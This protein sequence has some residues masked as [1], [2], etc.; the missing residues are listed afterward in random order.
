[1]S[2]N[3]SQVPVRQIR[4]N[5]YQVALKEYE[6]DLMAEASEQ[7]KQFQRS[8]A[9]QGQGW[10]CLQ[11][12]VNNANDARR[13]SWE[14]TM[15][16]IQGAERQREWD[17]Q[18]EQ[19]QMW[20]K[21][22]ESAIS[23][24]G[25]ELSFYTEQD[26][27][28][29]A[30][31]AKTYELAALEAQKQENW[32]AAKEYQRRAEIAISQARGVAGIEQPTEQDYESGLVK[33]KEAPLQVEQGPSTAENVARGII[34]GVKEGAGQVY[35]HTAQ[36]WSVMVNAAQILAKR[37]D[38]SL[39]EQKFLD[40]VKEYG[41]AMSQETG[42]SYWT[43]RTTG[44]GEERPLSEVSPEMYEAY[45][46]LGFARQLI[47]EATWPGWLILGEA[48]TFTGLSKYLGALA[49]KAT[50]GVMRGVEKG[51]IG[52]AKGAVKPGV[53]VE[54]GLVKLLGLPFKATGKLFD[55]TIGK[56]L[57]KKAVENPEKANALLSSLDKV[58]RGE[59]LN[60]DDIG[61]LM[62]FD[63][64]L[65]EAAKSIAARQTAQ[66]VTPEGT[67]V[68]I[69][70]QAAE[71]VAEQAV[72][73][74]G[75]VIGGGTAYNPMEGIFGFKNIDEA[76]AQ[77]YPQTNEKAVMRAIGKIPGVGSRIVRIIDPSMTPRKSIEAQAV[78]EYAAVFNHRINREA[79]GWK[80]IIESVGN[81]KFPTSSAKAYLRIENGIVQNVD[82]VKPKTQGA[83]MAI[84][85][86]LEHPENYV[87]D[88]STQALANLWKQIRTNAIREYE[89]RGM[90]FPA[91]FRFPR[92]VQ[93]AHG[94]SIGFPTVRLKKPRHYETMM[95]GLKEGVEY[96]D[97]PIQVMQSFVDE[98]TRIVA[99]NDF[100]AV[101]KAMG[102]TASERVPISIK[103][104]RTAA[105]NAVKDINYSIAT[106]RRM[107]TTPRGKESSALLQSQQAKSLALLDKRAPQLATRIRAMVEMPA[108]QRT[109]EATQIVKEL[110]AMLPSVR[111]EAAK[112]RLAYTNALRRAKSPAL[113]AG[114]AGTKHPAFTGR[115][116]SEET[117]RTLNEM[118]P[119]KAGH[120]TV[121][122][123]QV[124][125][126][127]RTLVANLDFSAWF[128][129]GQNV[130]ARRPDKWTIGVKESLKA[131]FDP[132]TLTKYRNTA[133]NIG[134]LSRHPDIVQ[135][136]HEFFTGKTALERIPH[137]GKAIGKIVAPFERAFETFGDVAR[138]EMAKALEPA[139]VKAGAQNQLGTYVNRLT[140]VMNTK[141]LGISGTQR[142]VE[143][144]WVAFAPRFMRASLAYIGTIFEKGITGA[145][146]RRTLAQ[147]AAGG[148]AAY[149]G[150]TQAL[151]QEAYL[152][153]RD[154]KFFTIE[155]GNRRIGVGGFMLSFVR[156]MGDIEASLSSH[157]GNEPMDLLEFHPI[158]ARKTNPIIKY[159]SSKA[160]I[161]SSML[162][163]GAIGQDYIGYPLE[164]PE[165][166]ARWLIV[167]HSLP[168]ALQSQFRNEY[169]EPPENRLAVL[170]AEMLGMR[171]YPDEP[172]YE[173]ADQYAQQ[174][175]GKDWGD[176]YQATK[177]GS[178][179][180]SER[181]EKLI[182]HFP[183][184]K[185]AYEDYKPKATKRW[186][187]AH[188]LL[189]DEGAVKDYY[190]NKLYKKKWDDLTKQE[191][192]QTEAYRV[193]DEATSK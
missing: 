141:A 119:S 25:D 161:L 117:A 6:R 156:F 182:E 111:T 115:I 22:R 90:K 85:D 110:Q 35:R 94:E 98:V 167:E 140:A 54:A 14:Y 10:S 75:K 101:V 62:D 162:Y 55:K 147:M 124:A 172:F 193:Y 16:K 61:R 60:T 21:M 82:A 171:V 13:V 33:R 96:V 126:S 157:R 71:Q 84:G 17:A 169:E 131:F 185:E 158:D 192:Q 184:L 170:G 145:E 104:W 26:K 186:Q 50:G 189:P 187:T 39:E 20:G 180:K 67:V 149:Y 53:W 109:R 137:I 150:A 139:F 79:Q 152:D 70:Q 103:N 59:A 130:L 11:S 168:I 127:L 122:A 52:L 81:G 99:A 88:E 134:I 95:Q 69:A 45:E 121:K 146:A 128:Y 2:F 19:G 15:Q 165:D 100:Q 181:Q 40:L 118:L 83:S 113:G 129:Q 5:A 178:Y 112:A 73:T 34:G 12:A 87:L 183:D 78:Q 49:P 159:V 4:R 143:S 80:A 114:E 97:D 154:P 144:T 51:A 38:L 102:K 47:G 138:I 166:W 41:G 123:Q 164:D 57:A 173:L 37:G 142:A 24:L 86:I 8:V 56:R 29:A 42:G 176:L 64:E 155:V 135:G 74:S 3:W 125:E 105:M 68:P 132:A 76:V 58:A 191:Q 108:E 9:V 151:G 174:V 148:T 72:D 179:T 36:D 1:M 120:A 7:Q 31:V 106:V 91:A 63:N 153:P 28:E 18:A 89:K 175:Y 65:G 116:F 23:K 133:D 46:D 188:G 92:M 44:T 163:E 93:G 30:I 48:A 136:V 32:D 77:L 190:A 160:S 177:A 107:A 66:A 43:G 27:R